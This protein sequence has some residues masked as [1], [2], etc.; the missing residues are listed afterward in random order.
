MTLFANILQNPQDTRARSDVRLMNLVVNF[1][2]MLGADEEN[3]GV[4]RM[5]GICAEFERVANVVLDRA[6][7]ESSSRR[8]RKSHEDASKDK[9]P[10]PTQVKTPTSSAPLNATP[11][12]TFTPSFTPDLNGTVSHY[13]YPK[14]DFS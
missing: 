8:K 11:S 6:D 7:K 12:T 1:L 4:K 3:G 2:S 10:P 13:S 9:H 5:L 14:W